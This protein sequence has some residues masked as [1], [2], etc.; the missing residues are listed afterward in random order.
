M[1]WRLRAPAWW[2]ID[3]V[4]ARKV[5]AFRGPLRTNKGRVRTFA[6]VDSKVGV[7]DERRNVRFDCWRFAARSF[8]L[9]RVT[10]LTK[11]LA[12]AHPRN[13]ATHLHHLV[14]PV[15]EGSVS[16]CSTIRTRDPKAF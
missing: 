3:F 8:C 13:Q 14:E 2:T 6:T 9:E 10:S 4:F 5:I 11:H 16:R 12:C 1:L 7:H 15:G